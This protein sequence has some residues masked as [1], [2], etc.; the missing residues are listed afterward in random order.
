[1]ISGFRA[2]SAVFAYFKW[3]F[4]NLGRY[5]LVR[6]P[7][8][9]SLD[10]AVARTS[11]PCRDH[12]TDFTVYRWSGEEDDQTQLFPITATIA[13]QCLPLHHWNRRNLR[14]VVARFAQLID[15]D[16]GTVNRI[17]LAMARV[18]IDYKNVNLI[19][20]ELTTVVGN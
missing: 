18:R 2:I 20:K 9:E 19:P 17:E 5:Y 4:Y 10:H 8:A 1:M 13:I 11:I 6:F 15:V 14:K 7:S 16:K 3:K 12:I